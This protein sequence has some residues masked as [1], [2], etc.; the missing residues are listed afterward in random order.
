M[1]PARRAA[2][3]AMLTIGCMG[4]GGEGVKERKPAFY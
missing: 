4:V 1:P 2:L 3:T